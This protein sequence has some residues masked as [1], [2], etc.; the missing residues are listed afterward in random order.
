MR[1]L[2]L[3]SLLKLLDRPLYRSYVHL[4][5]SILSDLRLHDQT[6][7]FEFFVH[8]DALPPQIFLNHLDAVVAV[9]IH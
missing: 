4:L 6:L 7:L 3:H 9:L 5:D 8:G 2:R 1:D